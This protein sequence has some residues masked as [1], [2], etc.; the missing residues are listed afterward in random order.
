MAMCVVVNTHCT[1]SSMPSLHPRAQRHVVAVGFLP[2]NLPASV[3]QGALKQ[4]QSI[5]PLP[6][7]VSSGLGGLS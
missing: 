7:H 1:L 2:P 5:G 6:F 3:L 4:A